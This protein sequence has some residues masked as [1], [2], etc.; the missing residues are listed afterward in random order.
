MVDGVLRRRTVVP[1]R[2]T[3]VPRRHT[4][5]SRRHTDVTRHELLF[6]SF[7]EQIG[8]RITEVLQNL[9]HLV[10][11][12]FNTSSVASVEL[13]TEVGPGPG[14]PKIVLERENLKNLLDTQLLC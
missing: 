2:R 5:G 9:H 3:V 7:C 11:C 14:H 8:A 12:E 4:V 10:Q 13:E 1:R 6:E